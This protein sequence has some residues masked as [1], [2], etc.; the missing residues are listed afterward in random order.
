MKIEK[1]DKCGS[2][3]D[4]NGNCYCGTWSEDFRKQPFS[5]TMEKALLAYDQ[6]REQE[7]SCEPLSMDHFSGNCAVYF[8]GDY[9]LCMKVKQFIL[10]LMEQVEDDYD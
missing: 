2:W 1:C 6:R 7:N 8:K 9:N 4:G 3:I 5:L 10:D